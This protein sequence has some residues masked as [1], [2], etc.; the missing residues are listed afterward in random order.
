VLGSFN[1]YPIH[2]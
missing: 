1:F 2:F